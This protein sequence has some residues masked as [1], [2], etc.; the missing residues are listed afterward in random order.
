MLLV[1][2]YITKLLAHI[3]IFKNM[4]IIAKVDEPTEWVNSTVVAE[5]KKDTARI[6]LDSRELNKATLREHHHIPALEDIAHKFA[7]CD[8]DFN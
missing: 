4:G 2:F 5:K 1:Q 6:C 3:D 7:V 8:C